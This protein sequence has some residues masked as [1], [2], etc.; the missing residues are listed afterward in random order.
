MLGH[1]S[2][3]AENMWSTIAGFL[4]PGE[5][6]ENAVRRETQEETGIEVG[7]VRFHATQPWPFPHSL[8]IGCIGFAKTTDITVD[9]HEIQD[10]RWFPRSDIKL[11]LEGKHPDGLFVPGQHAIAR[12]LIVAFA[13]GLE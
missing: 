12:S 9:P 11:M 6:I 13:E 1:E 3:F 5:D 7:E 4:E 2:R 10:A 8:M